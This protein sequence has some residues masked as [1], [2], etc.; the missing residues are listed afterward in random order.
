MTPTRST[1]GARHPADARRRPGAAPLAGRAGPGDSTVGQS[2]LLT[3]LLQLEVASTTIGDEATVGSTI[4]IEVVQLSAQTENAFARYSR[5]GDDKLGGWSVKRFGGFLK[6]SWRV[7][8]WTWG[9][10]DAATV[11]CRSVLH[12]GRVRRAAYLS[13]YLTAESDP[14]ELAAP[15]SA[16]S[17]S[18]CSRAPACRTIRGSPPC[19][20]RPRPS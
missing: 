18:T 12:P 20:T 14:R 3:T 2:D 8:D 11:L 1:P 7:N 19:A 17:S 10:L 15:L 6:R 16:T 9:R 4:P 5:T 13:G